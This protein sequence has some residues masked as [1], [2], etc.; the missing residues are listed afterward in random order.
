MLGRE[1]EK[2]EIQLMLRSYNDWNDTKGIHYDGP[3]KRFIKLSHLT[4]SLILK[5]LHTMNLFPLW[6]KLLRFINCSN[7]N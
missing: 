5:T 7:I 4:F 3:F 2:S 1:T 6:L